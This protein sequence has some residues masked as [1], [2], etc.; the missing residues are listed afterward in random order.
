MALLA[1]VSLFSSTWELTDQCIQYIL[2]QDMKGANE[3]K[4]Y[5]YKL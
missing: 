4:A 2:I 5:A 1:S 3:N